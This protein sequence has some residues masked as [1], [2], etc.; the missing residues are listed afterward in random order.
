MRSLCDLANNGQAILCTIHQPSTELFQVFDRLLHLKKG[1]Q[2]VYFSID[3][4]SS[5]MVEYFGRND[6]PRCDP[7]ANP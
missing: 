3:H 5:T 7:E 6:A 4:G 2:T 1:G